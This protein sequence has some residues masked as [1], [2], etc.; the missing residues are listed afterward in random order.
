MDIKEQYKRIFQYCCSHISDRNLAED[1]TQETFLRFLEHPEYQGSGRELQYLYT[2]AKHLC[3]D[4]YRRNKPE[5]L[6]EELPDEENTE[7]D[8]I[9][10]L[11]VR[12]ILDSLPEEER[13]IITLRYVSEL[14]VK[15]I[16]G[17][18]DVSWFAM[19][20]RIRRILAKM[21]NSFEKEGLR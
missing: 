20:R 6:T 7:P 17:I 14:S 3:I 18:Y 13:D 12:S 2:I 1:I 19:N 5:A 16:A 21:R 10:R 11:T 9:D 15:D 4:E 8:W